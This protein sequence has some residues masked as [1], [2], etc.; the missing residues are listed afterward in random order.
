MTTELWATL[1]G[2]I[3]LLLTNLAAAIKLWGE[4]Q[5]QKADRACTKEQRDKDSLELHDAVLK[6]EFA[7]TNLK[8][9]QT[10][11]TSVVEDLREQCA[12]LN[13]NIAK[14]D[15]NVGNLTE[16]IRDFKK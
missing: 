9:S 7:I 2:A 3:V 1:I 4:V 8:D 16:V 6:H 14:L 12:T 11:T 5:K 15:V 13:T 10:F